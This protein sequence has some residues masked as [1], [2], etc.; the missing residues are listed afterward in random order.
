MQG[1]IIDGQNCI[2]KSYTMQ[3]FIVKYRHYARNWNVNKTT[4][5]QG[6]HYARTPCARTYCTFNLYLNCQFLGLKTTIKDAILLHPQQVIPKKCNT[7]AAI[8]NVSTTKVSQSLHGEQQNRIRTKITLYILCKS[9]L[10][11][12]VDPLIDV[13]L[14]LSQLYN[15]A[16]LLRELGHVN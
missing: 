10:W 5:Y 11:I 15:C 3:G 9:N 8:V 4:L 13:L 1:H 6:I 16:T 7:I 2:P 14:L 12:H